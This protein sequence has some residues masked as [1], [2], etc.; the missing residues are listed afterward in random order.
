VSKTINWKYLIA[1]SNYGFQRVTGPSGTKYIIDNRGTAVRE[2]DADYILDFEVEICCDRTGKPFSFGMP[3][4]G[5]VFPA[6]LVIEEQATETLG[7]T[8][9][10]PE[11]TLEFTEI[12]TTEVT[13][14]TK[15]PRKRKE[16]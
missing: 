11:I 13:Q 5:Y 15:T 3:P 2:D 4:I 12:S 14:E 1:Q 7:K 6:P 10:L 8:F 9:T 16:D